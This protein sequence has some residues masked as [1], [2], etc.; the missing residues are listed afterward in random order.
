MQL[1]MELVGGEGLNDDYIVM[2][3]GV[4]VAIASLHGMSISDAR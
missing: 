2:E 3:Q 4:D 1:E